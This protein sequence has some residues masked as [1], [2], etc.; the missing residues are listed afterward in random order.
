MNNSVDEAAGERL[1]AEDLGALLG[2][3][4]SIGS[5]EMTE[6][7]I[8]SFAAQWDPLPIHVG[9]GEHF[10]GVIASGLHTLCAFQRLA[11]STVY[12][13]WA[14]V[15]GREM[16][17]MSLPRPVRPDDVLSGTVT[18]VDIGLSK[19]ARTRIT[20]QGELVNQRDEQVLSLML[21]AYVHG[22]PV[23]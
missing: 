7:E 19:N 17:K 20:I 8:R 4:Q 21:D 15:A 12:A 13:T 2:Q 3:P 9:D 10:G 23:A 6:E 5:Y 11:V 16:L 18:I 1:H 22:R 14:I